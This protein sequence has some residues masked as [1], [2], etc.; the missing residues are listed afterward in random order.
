MSTLDASNASSAQV[1]SFQPGPKRSANQ[2]GVSKFFN[3]SQPR[4]HLNGC[5]SSPSTRKYHAFVVVLIFNAVGITLKQDTFTTDMS[6]LAANFGEG[7]QFNKLTSNSTNI[8]VAQKKRLF[9]V[10]SSIPWLNQDGNFYFLRFISFLS[11][12]TLLKKVPKYENINFTQSCVY[13]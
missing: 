2:K 5:T 6:K 11:K 7:K 9:C 12:P 13:V 10:C 4:N 1:G 8:C 3:Q